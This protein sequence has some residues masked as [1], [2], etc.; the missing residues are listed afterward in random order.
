MQRYD[1]FYKIGI[2]HSKK[3]LSILLNIEI[4]EHKK[5]SNC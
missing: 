5:Q 2:I 4:T 3:Q 1:W